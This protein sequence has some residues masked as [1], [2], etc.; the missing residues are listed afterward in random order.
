MPAVSSAT[1]E[2]APR[3]SHDD[4]LLKAARQAIGMIREAVDAHFSVRLWDG[5]VEPL[6]RA[7]TPGLQVAINSPG[8][9]PSL[10]RRP[11]LDRLIRHYAHGRIDIE[12]GTVIDI[13]EPF[14]L[15]QTKRKALRRINKVA[16]AKTIWP[17]LTAKGDAPDASRDFGAG[18]EGTGRQKGDN[19][20]FIGF[21]YDV[22]NDFYKLFLDPEMQYSCG[23]FTEWTNSLE[24]AQRDKLDMICRKLRLKPGERM[25]DIG[26]GWGGLL[27]HAVQNYGVRGHGVT[28][29]EEQLALAQEKVERLGIADKITFELRDYQELD[30]RFD[31][32]ASIGMY[33]HIGL[34]NIP[35][36][37][38]KTRSLLADDGLFL[39]HAISRRAKRKSKRFSARPEQ[40]ALQ[41]YIFPGGELDDIGH[42]VSEMEKT[43]FEVHDVEA[44]RPHYEQT[45]RHWC[46]RLS[47]RREEAEALVGPEAYRIWVAY[48]GGCSLAFKR[49]SA[50]IYQ[51]L[52]GKSARGPRA[53]PPTRADLYE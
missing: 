51:T 42:S 49:G 16:L 47:A 35:A 23:Y 14:A 40:L 27:C 48:L 4:R 6:G 53:V 33:E 13:G 52:A 2:Q 1:A 3:P 17:L 30:G 28:L 8:V 20:R 31:K 32:I 36:Y 50:R 45:T 37:F 43:G 5:T 25:L 19:K 9:L 18:A 15:D 7:V 34:A 41:K 29:S 21:H 39:N 22:S 10:L 12:G 46:E 26:S 11:T 24:Q 44:W 38:Q